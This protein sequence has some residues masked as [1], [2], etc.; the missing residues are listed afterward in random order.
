MRPGPGFDS[1]PRRGDIMDLRHHLL[2]PVVG[3]QLSVSKNP[4][5]GGSGMFEVYCTRINSI[6]PENDSCASQRHLSR[7]LA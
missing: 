7:Y 4:R 2:V 1:A 6:R 3:V 5:A